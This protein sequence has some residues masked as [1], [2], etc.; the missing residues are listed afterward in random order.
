M[1]KSSLL[2]L[3]TA[4]SLSSFVACG[5]S[6][7]AAEEPKSEEAKADESKSD[8]SKSEEKSEAKDEKKEEKSAGG[9]PEVKRTP[10]DMITAPDV[11][12]MFSFND[13]EPKQKAEERCTASSKND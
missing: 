12:F 6:Q 3:V 1:R 10:K 4:L 7:P 11:T 5:G 13:S 8:D 9:M 2:A